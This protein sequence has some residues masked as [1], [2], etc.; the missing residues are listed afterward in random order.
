M[1]DDSIRGVVEAI[2][3]PRFDRP[4]FV[5]P[6]SLSRSTV[7]IVTTAGLRRPTEPPWGPN[8]QSF[9]V[10]GADEREVVLGHRD[11]NFDRVG[12]A[13][14]LN[15]AYP[16]DRLRDFAAEGVIGGLA[17]RHLSF[18]GAQDARMTTIQIDSGL[19]AA[20]LLREDGVDVVLLTP[21]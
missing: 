2:A 5:V 10:L 9:R 13:A 11:Q 4:A 14:D 8:D 3:V 7:A 19:A 17:P 1:N 6:P 18:M 12:I 20:R 16:I 15:V 21:V